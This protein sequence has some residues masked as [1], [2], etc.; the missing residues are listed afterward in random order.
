LKLTFINNNK[1][2]RLYANLK[3][4][5][6]FTTYGRNS[7]ITKLTHLCEITKQRE[8]T[9]TGSMP[10]TLKDYGSLYFDNLLN[11]FCFVTSTD[12]TVSGNGIM[13]S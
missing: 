2:L 8:L 10:Y 9:E 7:L 4:V 12:G 11:H 13:I 6:I 1:I 3:V 5:L